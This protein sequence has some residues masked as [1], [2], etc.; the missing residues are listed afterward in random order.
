[1]EL[2]QTLGLPLGEPI[3]P[4]E[5]DLERLPLTRAT[6]V[7]LSQASDEEL[8]QLYQRSAMAGA[9]GAILHTGAEILNRPSMEKM[10]D[11]DQ[12]LRRLISFQNDVSSAIR[13]LNLARERSERLGRST[14]PWDL[15]ELEMCI[16]EGDSEAMGRMLQHIQSEHIEEP[17]VAEQLYELFYEL[18]VIP[19][20]VGPPSL[21]QPAPAANPS[22]IWTP[23]SAQPEGAK[24][25]L[26]TPS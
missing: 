15:I 19:D 8:A 3:N 6:R 9:S 11:V 17:G 22:A 2:R 18:G 5:V 23:E 4:D 13:F 1:M 16:Y 25:K 10:V 20:D 26:W 24:Q 7:V 21:A 12:V 14:A